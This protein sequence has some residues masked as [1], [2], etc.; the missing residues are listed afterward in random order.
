MGGWIYRLGGLLCLVIA[1]AAGWWGIWLPYQQAMAGAA[2]VQYSLKVFVLAP[3]A[4]IFGLFFVIFGDSVPYR[5]AEAQKLTS[6][7]WALMAIVTLASGACF[8]WFKQAF[9]TLGYR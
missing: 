5:D 6:A 9:E 3:A 1:V 4:L 8:W 2:E 7:G